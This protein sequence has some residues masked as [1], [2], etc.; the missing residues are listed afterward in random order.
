MSHVSQ[1]PGLL[2]MQE[3]EQRPYEHNLDSLA[4]AAKR[5][6]L[7]QVLQFLHQQQ[8]CVGIVQDDLRAV[9]WRQ[10]RHPQ[11]D[12]FFLG[13]VNLLRE[14]RERPTP[15]PNPSGT[16]GTASPR[17]HDCPPDCPLCIENLAPKGVGGQLY[18][19][20]TTAGGRRY[21]ALANPYPFARTHFT[22][23]RH[24][25]VPQSWSGRDEPTDCQRM[26]EI[27]AD[28]YELAERLH[29]DQFIGFYN[30][31][32]S[33]AEHLHFHFF[34]APEGHPG[35]PLQV[36]VREAT[37]LIDAASPLRVTNYPILAFRV[38]GPAKEVVAQAAALLQNWRKEIG[39]AA[40]ANLIA[41]AEQGQLCLYVVPRSALFIRAPGF[42]GEVASLEVLGEFVFSSAEEELQIREDRIGYGRLWR[43]LRSVEPPYVRECEFLS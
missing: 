42:R 41:L 18:L 9:S 5:M 15:Q 39:R 24:E 40:G 13:Q 22:F 35:F 21:N 4:K 34:Q 32:G 38:W 11:S 10:F 12:G 27:V 20:I 26:T 29:V 37:R 19:P 25:H 31:R 23:A 43:V 36:A 3:F 7:G 33:I 30:N 1:E 6:P 14:K 17:P 16:T 8:L 2:S 28:L